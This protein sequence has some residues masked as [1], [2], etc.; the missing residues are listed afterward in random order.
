MKIVAD[1]DR[2]PHPGELLRDIAIPLTGKSKTEIAARLGVPR[3]ELSEILQERRQ[4]SLTI[5]VRLGK[6]FGTGSGLWVDLQTEY[7]LWR[8]ER[9]IDVSAIETLNLV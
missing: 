3:Q 4:V 9:E 2:P 7:D 5:S 8:A 1:K 6:L